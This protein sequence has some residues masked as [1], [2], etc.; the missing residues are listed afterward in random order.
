M[1]KKLKKL[2]EKFFGKILT[3]KIS[4]YNNKKW[5]SLL[6]IRLISEIEKEFSVKINFDEYEKL[7][8]YKSILLFLKKFSK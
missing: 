4:I 6:H 3:K 7:T 5:D 1:E 2:F 8:D